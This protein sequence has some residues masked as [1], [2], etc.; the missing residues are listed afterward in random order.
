MSLVLAA[1]LLLFEIVWTSLND[2]D[3]RYHRCDITLRTVRIRITQDQQ[4]DFPTGIVIFV[5]KFSLAQLDLRTV[6]SFQ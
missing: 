2:F 4:S 1:S 5:W 6:L 3:A